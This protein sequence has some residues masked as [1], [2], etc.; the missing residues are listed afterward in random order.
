[1]C[2]I[3]RLQHDGNI[4]TYDHNGGTVAES[5]RHPRMEG[6]SAPDMRQTYKLD[7]PEELDR[8]IEKIF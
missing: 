6:A 8:E 7:G 2:L 5:I 4:V 1:M 3:G